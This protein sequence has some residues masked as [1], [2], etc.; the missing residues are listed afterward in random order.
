[1]KISLDFYIINSLHVAESF[2][3][4]TGSL[5]V[6]KLPAF[7]GIRRLVTA[8]TSARHVPLTWARSI[9]SIPPHPTSW[10]SI[11]ILSSHLHLGLPIGLYGFHT[12][13]LYTPFIFPH[14][15]YMP[16]PSHSWF[17]YPNN[18]NKVWVKEL[19]VTKRE[20]ERSYWCRLLLLIIVTHTAAVN[21]KL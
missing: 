5:L 19:R 17:D 8:I 6:K 2:E 10:R 9:Q 13:T 12:K 7:Y 1:M 15:Y 11:L 4:R 16:S 3:N 14:T 21:L 20:R 18:C